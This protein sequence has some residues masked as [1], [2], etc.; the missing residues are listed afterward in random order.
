MA[1]FLLQET[2]GFCGDGIMNINTFKIVR[3]YFV[4]H[5]FMFMKPPFLSVCLS[6]LSFPL[7]LCKFQYVSPSFINYKMRYTEYFLLLG[8]DIIQ[9]L[10]P[11][12]CGNY[13]LQR[14]TLL[15][16]CSVDPTGA[17]WN[18]CFSIT[19]RNGST[20]SSFIFTQGDITRLKPFLVR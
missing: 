14:Y 8:G 16:C 9:S 13:F 18:I 19:I 4:L 3:K 7:Y 15:K 6:R 10:F 12:H 20:I 17:N 1:W 5:I 11:G 2:A